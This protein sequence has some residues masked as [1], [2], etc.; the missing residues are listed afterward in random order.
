MCVFLVVWGLRLS[1]FRLSGLFGFEVPGF[2][3]PTQLFETPWKG[4]E[5][6][7]KPYLK[8]YGIY[9]GSIRAL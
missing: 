6:I 7:P 8:P 2:R 9:E 1:G 3:L 5:T 4:F